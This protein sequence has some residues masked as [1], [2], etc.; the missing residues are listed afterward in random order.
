MVDATNR[1][2][3]FYLKL[4]HPPRYSIVQLDTKLAQDK[5][6]IHDWKRVENFPVNRNPKLYED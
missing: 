2:V 5:N 6:F 3:V 1:N 4:K